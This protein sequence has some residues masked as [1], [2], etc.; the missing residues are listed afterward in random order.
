VT[1]RG[2]VWQILEQILAVHFGRP[3]PVTALHREPYIYSTSFALEDLAVELADGTS[4]RLIRKDLGASGLMRDARMGK[5]S[6]LH[7]PCREIQTYQQLLSEA[8]L[9]TATCYGAV[10]DPGSARYWLFLEKV[11]GRELYQVGDIDA[12]VA[13]ARWLV[14]LHSCAALRV[15][16]VHQRN[17]HLISY[18]VDFYRRWLNRA[19]SFAESAGRDQQQVLGVIGE[20]L[21]IAVRRLAESPAT[22]VHG[23]FYASNVLVGDGPVGRRICPVDW[24]MAGIGSGL[25]DLAALCT[26]WDDKNV[27]A[28]ARG[29]HGAWDKGT[30]PEDDEDFLLLLHCCQLCLAVQ[31]LGWAPHWVAPPE[32]ARDWLAEASQLAVGLVL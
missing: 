6:F 28:I 26:G 32:H 16:S 20:G 4:L 18:D 10:V 23:E 21:E 5:P 12:W 7:E 13:A 17:R 14:D 24:E 30:W 19:K 8:Q 27:R 22:F 2:D 11:P 15:E 9:G 31:W 3:S 1:G 25:L 29:Y